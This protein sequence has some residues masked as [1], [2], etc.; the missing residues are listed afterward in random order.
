MIILKILFILVI[1]I[2]LFIV[3]YDYYNTLKLK[4]KLEREIK[5]NSLRPEEAFQQR[6]REEQVVRHLTTCHLCYDLY[7]NDEPHKCKSIWKIK[8]NN[9]L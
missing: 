1:V 8:L 7:F 9:L 5:H 3:I 4:R 2:V 6:I